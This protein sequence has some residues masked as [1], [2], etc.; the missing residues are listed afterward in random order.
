MTQ[1]IELSRFCSFENKT[2][3]VLHIPQIGK[4]FL[5]VER[6]SWGSS[7]EERKKWRVKRPSGYELVKHC[8]TPKPYNLNCIMREDL[9]FQVLIKGMGYV[10]NASF[11]TGRDPY[12]FNP[13]SI[14]LFRD[15]KSFFENEEDQDAL[16]DFDSYM[17][18]LYTY[19]QFSGSNRVALVI[20]DICYIEKVANE[21]TLEQRVKELFSF[22]TRDSINSN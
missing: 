6:M 1:F 19:G 2:F 15:D 8:L 7:P 4:H 16:A 20:F 14:M 18:N 5:T 11:E 9:S 10:K 3:G 13:G 22:Y 17:G 21:S 12:K